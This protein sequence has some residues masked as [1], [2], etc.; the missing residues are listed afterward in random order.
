[1]T[2]R[3][4]DWMARE[5]RRF[6]GEMLAIQANLVRLAVWSEQMPALSDINP[7][8]EEPPETDEMRRLR[9]WREKRTL[10]TLIEQAKKRNGE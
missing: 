10:A 3:E 4:L 5:R 8:H 9:E 2:L 7:Y 6:S 1:M